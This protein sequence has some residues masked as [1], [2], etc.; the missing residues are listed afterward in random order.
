[1]NIVPIK[2]K[3]ILYDH[4]VKTINVAIY[5]LPDKVFDPQAYFTVLGA[6]LDINSHLNSDYPGGFSYCPDYLSDCLNKDLD[7]IGDEDTSYLDLFVILLNSYMIDEDG[8]LDV[9]RYCEVVGCVGQIV[10]M[11]S[12][13]EGGWA[14]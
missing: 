9:D 6:L 8:S 12:Y 10:G 4:V 14:E 7:D 11:L 13:V 3:E 2:P 5:P 1:M